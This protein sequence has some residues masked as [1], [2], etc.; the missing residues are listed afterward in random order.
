MA[1]EAKHSQLPWEEEGNIVV[2]KK[3]DCLVALCENDTYLTIAVEEANAK[4]IA[5]ACNNHQKLIAALKC[6]SSALGCMVK[7]R[8]LENEPEN[9]LNKA[10][11]AAKV[12][13]A[14]A[15]EK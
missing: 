8:R 12:A 3:M 9:M 13:I 10:W 2:C 11:Q 4:F 5:K 14:E 7:V 1:K 15:E 6:A